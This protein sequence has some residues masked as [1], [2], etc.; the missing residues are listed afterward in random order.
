MIAKGARATTVLV[1]KRIMMVSIFTGSAIRLCSI[2]VEVCYPWC[3]ESV[4][5]I[6]CDAVV[7]RMK[8]DIFI[9]LSI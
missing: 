8:V 1:E 9:V 4:V 7:P 6:I 2:V 3:F 5:K